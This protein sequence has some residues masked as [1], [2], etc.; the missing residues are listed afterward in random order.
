MHSLYLSPIAA[1]SKTERSYIVALL[2]TLVSAY[3]LIRNDGSQNMTAHDALRRGN[4]A[5]KA[6]NTTF[7]G[8]EMYF[9]RDNCFAKCL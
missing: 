4:P 7:T 2:V 1:G 5:V 8:G 3:Q 6:R 9:M